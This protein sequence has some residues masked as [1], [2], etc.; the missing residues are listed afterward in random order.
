MPQDPKQIEQE[1]LLHFFNLINNRTSF[2]VAVDEKH[3]KVYTKF[4]ESKMSVITEVPFVEGLIPDDFRF[5]IQNWA[6][7]A[8]KLNPLIESVQLLDPVNGYGTG[9][10]VAVCPWPLSKRIMYTARYPLLD[11]KPGHH[12]FLMSERGAESRIDFTKQDAKDFA[13]AKLYVA[14]YSFEPVLK[15]E[16][17]VGTK[18]LYVQCADAGGSVPLKL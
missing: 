9:K 10:T 13:L 4:E 7:C 12:V 14:G 5:F 18:I 3:V 1:L 15:N 6:E 16:Q 8:P 11:Y 2:K 17:V